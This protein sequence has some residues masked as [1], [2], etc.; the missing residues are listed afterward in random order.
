MAAIGTALLAVH[1]AAALFATAAGGAAMFARKGGPG[2]RRAGKLFVPAMLVMYGAGI[3]YVA[4]DSTPDPILAVAAVIG[5][6][7]V[8]TAGHSARHRDGEAGAFH[9]AAFAVIL[10]CLAASILFLVLAL[11]A[12]SGRFYR[13]GPATI[14]PNIVIA[15]IA[16]GLD[17]SFLLRR[18]LA[19]NQRVARHVWRIGLAMLMVTFSSFAGDQIQKVFPEA[20]RGSFL[21]TL[22]ALALIAAV[23]FWLLRLRFAKAWRRVP[24]PQ[25][26]LGEPEPEPA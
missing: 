25:P 22:P 7:L 18:R 19:P 17:L 21:L 26:A 10:A 3:V 4:F 15:A 5:G 20:I 9:A 16:A 2:H 14:A 13:H 6:Y 23:V 11:E 1:I 8:V 24:R 12:P